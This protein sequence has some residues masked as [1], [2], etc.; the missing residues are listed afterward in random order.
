MN[1]MY[2]ELGKLISVHKSGLFSYWWCFLLAG[3]CVVIALIFWRARGQNPDNDAALP[4]IIGILMFLAV[5]PLLIAWYYSINEA[6]LYERGFVYRTRRAITE[7][8][9]EDIKE[10]YKMSITVNANGIRT[11]AQ[12]RYSVTLN[13]GSIVRFSPRLD[14]VD[15]LGVVLISVAEMRGLPVH[16]GVPYSFSRKN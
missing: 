12:C 15:K 10:F 9:W 13:D 4:V 3:C 16:S 8:G 11:P 1:L 7:A 2:S 6:H 5:I 14:N